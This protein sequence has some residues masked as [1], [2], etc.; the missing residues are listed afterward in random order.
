MNRYDQIIETR[1]AL[2]TESYAYMLVLVAMTLAAV[3][4]P[5]MGAVATWTV[6]ASGD[7]YMAIQNVVADTVNIAGMTNKDITA[8]L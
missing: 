7:D 4:G 3:A 2:R 6:N 8:K 5:V 1:T